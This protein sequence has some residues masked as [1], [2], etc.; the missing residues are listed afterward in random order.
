ML[1]AA[2]F[3]ESPGIVII[4]PVMATI[5]PAP[6]DTY[7]SLTVISK[8]LGLPSFVASSESEYCV[9]AIHIGSSEYPCLLRLFISFSTFNVYLTPLAP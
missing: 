8:S 4:E 5:N 7:I 9:F 3:L 2:G 1:Y 6:A